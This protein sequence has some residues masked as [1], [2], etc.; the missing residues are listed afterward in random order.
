[1]KRNTIIPKDGIQS[2]ERIAETMEHCKDMIK[3]NEENRVLQEERGNTN[4]VQYLKGAS[5]AYMYIYNR[6]SA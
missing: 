5:D 1:M 6:L 3:Y 4:T 2:R